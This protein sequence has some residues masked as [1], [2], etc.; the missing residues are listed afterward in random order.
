MYTDT[1]APG[2]MLA[3]WGRQFSNCQIEFGKT[4]KT[5]FCSYRECGPTRIKWAAALLSVLRSQALGVPLATLSSA[6]TDQRKIFVVNYMIIT[7]KG[8]YSRI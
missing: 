4:T 7:V 8:L 2:E 5:M 3:I 6:T 1:P